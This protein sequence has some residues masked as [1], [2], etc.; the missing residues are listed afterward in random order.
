[1]PLIFFR[2]LC[3]PHFFFFRVGFHLENTLL[4]HESN[5]S[6]GSSAWGCRWF[7]SV[8]VR[9]CTAR[10][11]F[12]ANKW[13]IEVKCVVLRELFVG[14]LTWVWFYRLCRTLFELGNILCILKIA[15]IT[16]T[17]KQAALTSVIE[18]WGCCL[19]YLQIPVQN[20][21]KW[22]ERHWWGSW[23]PR[24]EQLPPCHRGASPAQLSAALQFSAAAFRAAAQPDVTDGIC[25]LYQH[26]WVICRRR[27]A[28][29]R[30]E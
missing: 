28:R 29:S 27:R 2:Y 10:S 7:V 20:L 14:A 13:A 4:R 9:S 11:C 23:L 18:E 16:K 24:Y 15:K 12:V 6:R 30:S 25:G 3:L 26:Q 21:I 22:Q 19:L 17:K 1:M 5:E 8:E